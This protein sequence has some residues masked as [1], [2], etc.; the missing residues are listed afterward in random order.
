MLAS[1]VGTFPLVYQGFPCKLM[2]PYAS[3]DPLRAAGPVP[4]VRR[5]TGAGMDPDAASSTVGLMM[6]LENRDETKAAQD[7]LAVPRS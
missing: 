1:S 5:G 3:A 6:R 2:H 4:R 7:L